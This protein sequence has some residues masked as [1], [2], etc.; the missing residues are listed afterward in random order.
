MVDERLQVE[1]L[2][3]AARQFRDVSA[4]EYV[5]VARRAVES[6]A[7][8]AYRFIMWELAEHDPDR[9]DD[10]IW[11]VFREE[12]GLGGELQSGNEGPL[13]FIEFDQDG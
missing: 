10:R 13:D 9:Y 12:E 5:D 6:F 7:P 3:A 4:E 2:L 1:D 11:D 8:R